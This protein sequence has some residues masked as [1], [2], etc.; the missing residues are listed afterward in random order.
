MIYYS[1]LGKV[2]LLKKSF[3]DRVPYV[4]HLL[5]SDVVYWSVMILFCFGGARCW[6]LPLA[7]CPACRDSEVSAG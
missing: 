6:P 3:W 4:T 5:L 7:S 1:E 2:N